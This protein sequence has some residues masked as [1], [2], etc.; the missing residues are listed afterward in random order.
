MEDNH[1]ADDYVQEFVLDHL[2]GVKKENNNNSPINHKTWTIPSN[3]EETVSIKVKS[4]SQSQWYHEDRKVNNIS[5]HS[6]VYPH[7]PMHGQPM[8]INQIPS[9][10]PSTPPETPPVSSPNHQSENY[11]PYYGQRPAGL[12]DEMMWL[13]NALRGEPQPLDLRPLACAVIQENPGTWDR[14]D[15]VHAA[16]NNGFGQHHSSHFEHIGSLNV[17]QSHSLHHSGII[18]RPQSVSSTTSTISPRNSNVGSNGSYSSICSDKSDIINDDLLMSLSVRELNKRLHGCPR[19]EVVRLKQKRRTLKNRGYAQN[20]RSKRLQQRHDL[21]ITNRQLHHELQ[22]IKL[23]LGRVSQERD[24]LKQK[25]MRNNTTIPINGTHELHSDG[26][27][28]PEFYL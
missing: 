22:K 18:N 4:L 23:E 3:E 14:K 8:L 15:Y 19:E 16:S 27:G 5:P 13:P 28:S 1:L 25:L 17:M 21:E 24:H 12:M 26:S 11:S 20:C 6:D 9:G 2:E 7:V 10:A